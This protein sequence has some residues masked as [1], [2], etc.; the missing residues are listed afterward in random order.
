MIAQTKPPHPRRLEGRRSSCRLDAQSYHFATTSPELLRAIPKEA[1]AKRVKR[2]T[3]VP[4]QAKPQRQPTS[5]AARSRPQPLQ[6]L[7][8]TFRNSAVNR[9]VDCEAHPFDF[10][11]PI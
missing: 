9:S 6:G 2:E 8:V 1:S 3:Y 10:R 4:K 7:L 11:Q 5:H